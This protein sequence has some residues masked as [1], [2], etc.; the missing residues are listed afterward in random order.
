VQ[1]TLGVAA[2][3]VL[4]DPKGD[5]LLEATRDS[6][7]VVVGL[8]ERWRRE[9]LGRVRSALAAQPGRPTLLVRRGLRP[10]A[11]APSRTATRFTWTVTAG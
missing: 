10:G 1:R 6:G 3:P 7:V 2:E 5:A 9:G 11:L 4:V 8:T